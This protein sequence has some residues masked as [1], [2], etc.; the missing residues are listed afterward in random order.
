MKINKIDKKELTLKCVDLLAKTYL[1]LGQRPDEETISTMATILSEDLQKDFKTMDMEDI[2]EA[3][4]R[5]VRQTDKFHLNV[6]TYYHWIKKYRQLLW[7]AAYEVHTLNKNPKEV[8]LYKPK[9]KL[10]K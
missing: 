4:R 3:F 7:D 2:Q 9:Q 8:P 6:K 10:L 5:G 1:E